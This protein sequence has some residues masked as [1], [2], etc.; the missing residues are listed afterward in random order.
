[1]QFLKINQDFIGKVSFPLIHV[2]VFVIFSVTLLGCSATQQR[3]KSIKEWEAYHWKRIA[4]SAKNIPGNWIS[5]SK[6][7]KDSKFKAFK[8]KGTVRATPKEAVEALRYR[9]ENWT[10]FYS[11][12]EVYFEVLESDSTELLVYSIFKLPFP[13]RDRSMCEKFTI[14]EDSASG[15]HEISW[16]QEWQ[17]APPEKGIIR[18]PV[19]RGSW[20]FEP[21]DSSQSIATYEVYTDPG[22]SLPAWMYNSTVQ[23]G[24]PKELNDIEQIAKELQSKNQA[25]YHNQP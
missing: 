19:A 20:T 1:M 5:Y 10:A 2:V 4:E 18:M 23:K 21:I 9:I 22:G 17:K 12:K 6:N 14:K 25:L 16:H 24:L 3:N 7:I 11:E 8:I 13:F 15:I